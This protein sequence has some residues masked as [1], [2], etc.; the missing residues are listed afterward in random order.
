MQG[1]MEVRRIQITGGS[2]FMI[3]LP[4]SWADSV[5]LKK[6]DPVTVSPQPNGGLLI[7][8]SGSQASE[9]VPKR[10]DADAIPD[11]EA[12][13]RCLIGAYIAGHN[14]I[15]VSS[16]GILKGSYLEA[17]SKF[18]QTSIGM[19]I[20]EEEEDHILI[21]DLMDH[22]EILPQKNVRREYLL[23]KR[24]IS[25]TFKK[26]D[27]GETE[28]LGEMETRDTE[29]DRLHWL[30]QRQCSI[31][32]RDIALTNRMGIDLSSVFNCVSVSKTL[33]R[34]G[35]HAVL[36]S[37]HLRSLNG[38]DLDQ[39]SSALSLIGPDIQ[40][41]VDSAIESWFGSDNMKAEQ[42]ISGKKAMAQAIEA[43]F[44]DLADNETAMMV[45]GSCKR[46]S[47]YCTDI[48]ESA[49][50]LSMEKI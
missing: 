22:S 48:A 10:I 12:L 21:K 15:M 35:D 27:P 29:V 37:R 42:L 17:I 32:Q 41:T 2:S 19:E 7:A 14:Q 33:E 28:S 9:P 49:I 3:T 18:T 43:V 34:M 16:A 1:D 38:S 47:E 40:K 5:G 8:V 24:M 23:V 39:V 31:H 20:V 25:D 50:N 11:A 30:V 44:S 46:I 13:Y 36:V 26:M 4:K 6:N 45:E